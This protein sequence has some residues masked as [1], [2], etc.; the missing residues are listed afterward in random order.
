VNRIQ[1]EVSKSL[2]TAAVKDKLLSQGAIPGGNSPAEFARHIDA[3]HRKWAQV[4]KVSG[5]KAD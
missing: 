2:Q 5:A 3:E 1:Q 4:V